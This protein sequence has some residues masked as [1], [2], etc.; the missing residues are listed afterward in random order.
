MIPLPAP[1]IRPPTGRITRAEV[2]LSPEPVMIL[3]ERLI[4]SETNMNY[5]DPSA[6]LQDLSARIIAIRDSL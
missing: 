4:I 5:E 6:T 1:M 3:M 2:S